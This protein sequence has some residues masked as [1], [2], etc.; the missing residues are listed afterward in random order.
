MDGLAEL[1]SEYKI[2]VDVQTGL[3]V[4]TESM[5]PMGIVL[6]EFRCTPGGIM[7]SVLALKIRQF[8]HEYHGTGLL[9]D[10]PPHN[11]EWINQKALLPQRQQ[12]EVTM[13]DTLYEANTNELDTKGPG[14]DTRGVVEFYLLM[15]RVAE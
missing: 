3:K 6:I 4:W 14:A 9:F 1:S 8:G 15:E 11:K 10:E 5:L 7:D 13:T 2:A 12:Q